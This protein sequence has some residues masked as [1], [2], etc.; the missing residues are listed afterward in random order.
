MALLSLGIAVGSS[1]LGLN[2]S[3]KARKRQRSAEA[4]QAKRSAIANVKNRRA[5]LAAMRREQSQQAVAAIS[6]GMGGGS[7]DHATK[8]SIAA[9]A[10]D[11]IAT[12]SQQ[13][14]LGLAANANVAAANRYSNQA[15]TY[16]AVAGLAGQ[17]G[18]YLNSNQPLIQPTVTAEPALPSGIN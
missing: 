16:G 17:V 3:S 14:E 9:Q 12:Q 1:L 8:S 18:N 2:A 15:N 11:G 10:T 6:S 5:A 13:I 4:L 7:G